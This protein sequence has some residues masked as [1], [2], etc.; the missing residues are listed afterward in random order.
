MLHTAV[1]WLDG[2]S[3]PL[4]FTEVGPVRLA[5]IDLEGMEAD[6]AG[7]LV[8]LLQQHT[9]DYALVELSPEF[10]NGWR[11]AVDVFTG[12]GYT[13]HLVPDKGDD[14]DEFEAAPLAATLARGF[15]PSWLETQATV[16]FASP[17]AQP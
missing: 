2:N 14:V 17:T 11:D 12:T 6:A 15:V 16:L 8:P 1:G 4:V 13:A 10:G 7:V 3:R 9:V 5:K